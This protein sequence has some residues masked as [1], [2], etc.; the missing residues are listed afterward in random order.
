MLIEL[1]RLA[2]NNLLRARARLLMT[3]GGVLVGTTAIILL[4]AM[5]NGL[6]RAAEAG[7]GSSTSL[8]R[9]NVSE[10][11]FW[12]PPTADAPVVEFPKLTPAAVARFQRIEGVQAVIPMKRL[13]GGELTT[14]DGLIGYANLMGIDPRYLPYLGVAVDQGTLELTAGRNQAIFTP[15]VGNYFNDPFAEEWTPIQIDLLST[16]LTMRLYRNDESRE[17]NIQPVG[18]LLELPDSYRSFMHIQDVIQHNAWVRDEPFDPETFVYDE[19]IVVADSR[20]TAS[21]VAQAIREMDYQIY[22]AIE[23]I[24]QLNGFF[25]SM[26]LILGGVGGVALLVAAFGV[27]N[28]MTM[29]ILE[30]TKEI[31]IMKAVGATDRDVMT[32]FLIEAGLVGF[33]GGT[34]GVS[35]AVL[36][37][38]LI[39]GVLSGAGTPN[40][41]DP[42]GGGIPFIGIDLSQLNGQLII[43][44]PEL[45]LFAVAVA[46]M[47]GVCAGVYPAFRAAARLQ[48]IVALKTE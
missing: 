8:T 43:I 30:R 29:A 33:I 27:A 35:V 26:R 38:N 6:Q 12:G 25:N 7:I 18:I 14:P 3:A 9:I 22:G 4:L 17:I 36:L 42:Y 48:P 2:I 21:S 31:G 20:E 46:T 34:S 1:I 11:W 37:Q 32:V 19:V 10:K 23:F 16:P 44:P 39:N 41:D 47:V 5:T 28:T 40:P 15:D 24:E 45:M 13:E